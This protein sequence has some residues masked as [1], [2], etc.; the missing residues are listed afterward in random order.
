MSD[1]PLNNTEGLLKVCIPA[2]ALSKA[3]FPDEETGGLLLR[4]E[5]YQLVGIPVEEDGVGGQI[6]RYDLAVVCDESKEGGH[7]SGGWRSGDNEE[8]Y[9]HNMRYYYYYDKTPHDFFTQ[10]DKCVFF[11]I[12]S[13]NSSNGYW[14][15]RISGGYTTSDFRSYINYLNLSA[16][17]NDHYY[18][19]TAVSQAQID[20]RV[21]TETE[22]YGR[23]YSQFQTIC[24]HSVVLTEREIVE[25]DNYAVTFPV[26]R[27]SNALLQFK[28]QLQDESSVEMRQLKISLKNDVDHSADP[29]WYHILSGQTFTDFS[30]YADNLYSMYS[31]PNVNSLY[32]G[33]VDASEYL[34]F[35]HIILGWTASDFSTNPEISYTLSSTPTDRYFYAC[36]VPQSEY[37]DEY[38]YLFFEAIDSNGKV[39]GTAKKYLPEGGFQAG[40]RYDFTLTLREN[41]LGTDAGNA[42]SYGVGTL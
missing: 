2:D 33:A 35:D 22:I 10:F 38:S 7:Q 5:Y 27:L 9:E 21:G 19:K 4:D 17:G 41:D 34:V 39:V 42:G 36:V 28:I 29:A 13:G 8:E 1:A 15:Y 37:I 14:H 24:G 40:K 6:L 20:A 16:S 18:F 23:N 31:V 32:P 11:L 26:L 30:G 25:R 12:G 3:Y